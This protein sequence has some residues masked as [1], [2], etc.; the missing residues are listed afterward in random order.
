MELVARGRLCVWRER[1]WCC[2]GRGC[3]GRRCGRGR[4]R[5]RRGGVGC[6][7][8]ALGFERAGAQCGSGGHVDAACVHV[9]C[10]G[11]WR[12]VCQWCI[13][14]ERCV[15]GG[16]VDRARHIALFSIALGHVRALHRAERVLAGGVLDFALL[17]PP[18][19]IDKPNIV[20]ALHRLKRL[21]DALERWALNLIHS[22][23]RLSNLDLDT[24][25]RQVHALI[26]F[27]RHAHGYRLRHGHRLKRAGAAV[28]LLILLQPYAHRNG[29]VVPRA[30]RGLGML[31][32]VRLSR[33]RHGRGCG[34]V[35]VHLERL[36]RSV[37][38]LLRVC[39]MLGGCGVLDQL[40]G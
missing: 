11:T 38:L 12:L 39:G 24:L 32:P 40:C 23:H 26:L 13:F 16:R 5:G 27:Y 21:G 17:A 29:P 4:G 20:H 18:R 3:G 14:G 33:Y 1:R 37:H 6:R 36:R 15:V 2:C 9:L 28:H 8:R 10:D 30:Q 7:R 22:A 25:R 19:D 35:E 31:R 34:R